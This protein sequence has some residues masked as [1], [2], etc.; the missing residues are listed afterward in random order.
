LSRSGF[1][2]SV[3]DHTGMDVIAYHPSTKQRL[4][5]TVKSRTR[6]AGTE[7]DS[8]NLF[9]RAK[10]DRQKLLDACEAFSC[11]P[12]IAIYAECDAHA[13]LFLTSLENYDTRY[14]TRGENAIDGWRMTEKHTK[15]YGTD[16][17]VKHIPSISQL[18]IG[19]RTWRGVLRRGR[20]VTACLVL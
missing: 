16:S 18:T 3:V 9:Q 13:D 20:E 19:G 17:K 4:G 14:G 1:E 12:W 7:M 10:N 11:E 8:V 5:I 6:K 2:V 15:E